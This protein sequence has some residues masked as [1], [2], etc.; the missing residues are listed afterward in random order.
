MTKAS[1]SQKRFSLSTGGLLYLVR[2]WIRGPELSDFPIPTQILVAIALLWLPLVLLSLFEGSFT[3]TKVAQPLFAD[4]VPHVRL[5]I[6]IPLLLLADLIIDPA[7]SAAIRN[8][9]SGGTVPDAEQ[10]RFQEAL[11]EIRRALDSVWPDTV[12]IVLAFGITWM[13]K[14]GYGESALQAVAT[15]WMWS[16]QHGDVQFSAAGWWYLLVSGPMFQVILFRWFWRFLI[17][18]AF[19][20]RVSRLSLVLQPTDPDLAGGLGYLGMAQQTFVAVFFAFATVASSTIAHDILAEGGTF[21]DAIPEI[22]VL[23]LVFV[24]II[25]APL[26]FFSKQ[27]F[28]ARRTGL[29]EYGSL[30][31]RLSQAFRQKWV[32]E[33]D[34]GVGKELLASTDPSAIADYT[35]AYDNVRSMRSIPATLRSVLAV[36]GVLLV[37]FLPLALTEF[38]IQDLLQRLADALV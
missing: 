23:V 12:I 34:E 26:L 18:A 8:L 25:Y 10:P 11:T 17:W 22:I 5:L 2:R 24:V 33:G 3:G 6:A 13:F 4:I 21:D 15:S 16:R 14:P 1:G 30:G 31:Y 37:P 19:L 38:S 29:N 9:E 36:A 32:K 20:F 35:A 7:I 27:L 28:M